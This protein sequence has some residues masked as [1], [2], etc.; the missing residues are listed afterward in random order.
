MR[1]LLIILI[2]VILMASCKSNPS[3]TLFGHKM[4][5]EK[6]VKIFKANERFLTVTNL[7]NLY[8]VWIPAVKTGADIRKAL[9]QVLPADFA[10]NEMATVMLYTLH[11]DT[12]KW[13]I[14]LD[15]TPAMSIIRIHDGGYYHDYLE[16][17]D[18]KFEIIPQFSSPLSG[19]ISSD[20]IRMLHFASSPSINLPS[21]TT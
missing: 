17:K 5:R 19:G 11:N 1:N 8:D 7:K 16:R 21:A 6:G 4:E 12:T 14:A 18:K 2:P 13:D 3:Y 15:Q 9:S 20:D 10:I